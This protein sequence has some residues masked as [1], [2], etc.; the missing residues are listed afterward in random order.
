MYLATRLTFSLMGMS[1]V[2]S[3]LP[4]GMTVRSVIIMLSVLWSGSAD[5]R[6]IHAAVDGNGGVGRVEACGAVAV[7]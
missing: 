3:T 5:E 7:S 1:L 4:A 6:E 2:L